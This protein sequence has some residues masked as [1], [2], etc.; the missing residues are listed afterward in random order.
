MIFIEPYSGSVPIVDFIKTSHGPIDIEMYYLASRPIL[1]AMAAAQQRGQPVQVIIDG[2]PY[3]MPRHLVA[4][5][6]ARIKATGAEVK[7]APPGL[8][9]LSA[10]I[11]PNTRW[12]PQGRLL[13]PRI[14]ITQR[15]IGIANTS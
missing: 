14:G 15:F 4:R 5:E 1:H 3:K 11:T 7:V 8:I 13:G 9:R 10:L 2:R 6:I 12:H